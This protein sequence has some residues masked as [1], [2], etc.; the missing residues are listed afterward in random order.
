MK[1]QDNDD[2]NKGSLARVVYDILSSNLALDADDRGK[3]SEKINQMEWK[4]LF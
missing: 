1:N 4:L 3:I 2:K